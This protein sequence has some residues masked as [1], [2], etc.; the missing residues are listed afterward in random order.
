MKFKDWCWV[1]VIIVCGLMCLGGCG[2]KDPYL[3]AQYP[4]KSECVFFNSIEKQAMNKKPEELC[5]LPKPNMAWITCTRALRP[6]ELPHRGR[7]HYHVLSQFG[8]RCEYIWK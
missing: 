2:S 3:K 5:G 7:H 8:N 6:I 4:L 1:G